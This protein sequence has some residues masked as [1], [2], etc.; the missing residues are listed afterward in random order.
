LLEAALRIQAQHGT[1]VASAYLRV[2]GVELTTALR[3]LTRPQSDVRAELASWGR[4]IPN[5]VEFN[6]FIYESISLSCQ[7]LA[8]M[9]AWG[10]GRGLNCPS[11][12]SGD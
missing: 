7:H 5:L 4:N 1:T 2:Y 12:L 6:Q 10:C 11:V 3:V 8:T 9:N